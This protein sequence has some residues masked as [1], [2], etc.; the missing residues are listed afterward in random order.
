MEDR[1]NTQNTHAFTELIEN[2][3]TKVDTVNRTVSEIQQHQKQLQ[4]QRAEETRQFRTQTRSQA[5]GHTTYQ[6]ASNAGQSLGD[7]N[8]VEKVKAQ[9]KGSG[10]SLNLVYDLDHGLLAEASF[11]PL[12]TRGRLLDVYKRLKTSEQASIAK[13]KSEQQKQ[14]S[15]STS[16]PNKFE[17]FQGIHPSQTASPSVNTLNAVSQHVITILVLATSLIV[18]RVGF[19]VLSFLKNYVQDRFFSNKNE[20]LSVTTLKEDLETGNK[21][22]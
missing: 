5:M 3:E 4:E 9:L 8:F 19:N 2:L 20:S 1:P 14:E 18:G 6:G 12:K 17:Y 10:K 13:E 21:K 15:V 11:G 7:S 16:V 22:K